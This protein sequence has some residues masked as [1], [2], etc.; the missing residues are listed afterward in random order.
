MPFT[1]TKNI[2]AA[3]AGQCLVAGAARMFLLTNMRVCGTRAFGRVGTPPCL[4]AGIPTPGPFWPFSK[5]R[6]LAFPAP[7][8]RATFVSTLSIRPS[9]T[10]PMLCILTITFPNST[11]PAAAGSL[12]ASN[13]CQKIGKDCQAGGPRERSHSPQRFTDLCPQAVAARQRLPPQGAVGRTFEHDLPPRSIPL[14]KRGD[15][16]PARRG[17]GTHSSA[18]R[19]AG[20][21]GPCRSK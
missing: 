10:S 12:H 8:L 2:R 11:A 5:P 18:D 16:Q 20:G 17:T 15:C 9:N 3:E 21:R 14:G 6:G 19:S 4:V 13:G 1:V 7:A